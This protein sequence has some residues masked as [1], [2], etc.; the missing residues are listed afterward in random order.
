MTDVD[1]TRPIFGREPAVIIN[2]VAALLATLI[3]FMPAALTGEQAGAIVAALTA[4][5][6]I[7]TAIKVRPVAP[8]LFVGAITTGATLAGAFGYALTQQQVG[9]LAAAS[10]AL[11]TVLV[12]RPQSTPAADPRTINGVLVAGDI[13]R[14]DLPR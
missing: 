8:T 10:V 6:A 4:A 2:A 12:I 7:W 1:I 5:A 9:T 14:T 3:G 11:M 13:R